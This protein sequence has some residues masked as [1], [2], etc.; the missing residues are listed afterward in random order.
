MRSTV[1]VAMTITGYNIVTFNTPAIT[2]AFRTAYAARMGVGIGDVRITNIASARRRRLAA[3]AE[4]EED[5]DKADEKARR[6]LAS[7]VTFD[8][9][10]DFA[11]DAAASAYATTVQ[12][13][14]GTTIAVDFKNALTEAG[15]TPPASLAVMK[16]TPGKQSVTSAPTPAPRKPVVTHAAYTPSANVKTLHGYLTRL[17]GDYSV[18]E[19]FDPE[20]TV[21]AGAVFMLVAAG[22]GIVVLLLWLLFIFCHSCCKS[23]KCCYR[24]S[25]SRSHQRRNKVAQSIIFLLFAGLLCGSIKGRFSF[26]KA[27]D[28][29]VPALQGTAELFVEMENGVDGMIAAGLQV[30]AG[31]DALTAPPSNCAGGVCAACPYPGAAAAGGTDKETWD[32]QAFDK[33]VGTGG[34][35]TAMA[36]QVSAFRSKGAAMKAQIAGLVDNVREI[37]DKVGTDGKKYVDFGIGAVVLFGLVICMLGLVGTWCLS[38]AGCCNLSALLAVLAQLSGFLFLVLLIVLVAIQASAST[39]FAEVCYQPVPETAMI[40]LLTQSWS[41]LG[42]TVLDKGSFDVPTLKYYMTCEGTNE[43]EAKLGNAT[44]AIA[45]L[46]PELAKV[47][48]CDTAGLKGA[49]PTAETAMATVQYTVS[50]PHINDLLLTFTRDAVCTHMVDGLYFLWAAQA[51]SGVFLVFALVMM[52]LAQQ[53]F[54]GRR[55][56]LVP[57]EAAITMTPYP[58]SALAEGVPR[59]NSSSNNS[60]TMQIRQHAPQSNIV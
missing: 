37:A 60:G 19:T 52:D 7:S 51:A 28:A 50:C 11:S 5:G 20:K 35:A 55:R 38:N 32:T 33:L 39:I 47:K 18:G 53:S 16:A 14:S 22:A 42:W 17:P 9:V 10:V 12:A 27:A 31:F 34:A 58:S 48:S 1:T 24:A 29:L 8:I 49:L 56:K 15:E 41:G 57:R 46:G 54:R 26:H 30:G 2:L 21:E 36:P 43:L 3:A 23:C 59:S 40:D 25:L 45:A 44:A 6:R 13:Q 4:H